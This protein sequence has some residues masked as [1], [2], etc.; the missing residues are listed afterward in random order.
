MRISESGP[1]KV[2]PYT[3][4]DVVSALN[5]IAPHD[6]RQFFQARVYAANPRAPLGGIEG[7]GWRLL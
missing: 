5:D 1:P 6:W 2:V 7:S 4:D 3:L